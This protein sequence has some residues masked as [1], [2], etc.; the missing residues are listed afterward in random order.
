M[1]TPSVRPI[2]TKNQAPIPSLLA[3]FTH[4]CIHFVNFIILL[5][6]Q[7]LGSTSSLSKAK[8]PNILS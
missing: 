6:N 8:T 2:K 7:S 4:F 5:S 3:N 1:S